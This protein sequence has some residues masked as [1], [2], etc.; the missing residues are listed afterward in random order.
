MTIAEALRAEGY[1]TMMSGKWHCGGSYPR[2]DPGGWRPG[3][4]KRPVPPD[5][6]FDEWYGTPAGAGSYFNPKPLFH[7][8]TLVEPDAD[9]Y[10]YTDAVSDEAVR[11]IEETPGD[12][13][14]FFLHVAYTA[15]H[16]P[17]HAPE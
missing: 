9:D 8:H 1:R 6:G 4:P 16:W 5:R 11:M 17:L 12:G 13:R 7:N 2:N 14:P 15:P 10:Y 3:D